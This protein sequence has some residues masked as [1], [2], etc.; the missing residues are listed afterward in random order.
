MNDQISTSW[1]GLMCL[2]SLAKDWIKLRMEMRM[3]RSPESRA[4][5]VNMAEPGQKGLTYYRGRKG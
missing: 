4:A 1:T 5:A 3:Y 2:D